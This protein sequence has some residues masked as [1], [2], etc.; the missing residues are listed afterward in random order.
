MTKQ[1]FTISVGR[2]IKDATLLKDYGVRFR[3]FNFFILIVISLFD[4]DE[5]LKAHN[6][7]KT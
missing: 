2:F 5:L 1:D 7:V 4:N 3:K 6:F